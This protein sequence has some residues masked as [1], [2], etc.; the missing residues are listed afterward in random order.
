MGI[1][2]AFPIWYMI[3]LSDLLGSFWNRLKAGSVILAVYAAV[4]NRN[5]FSQDLSKFRPKILLL[6][7]F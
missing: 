4:S 5:R 3:F 2:L 7:A 1:A 6:G